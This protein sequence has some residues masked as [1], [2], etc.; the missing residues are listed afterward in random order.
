MGDVAEIA[1]AELHELAAA[2]ASF[3]SNGKPPA[4]E[5]TDMLVLLNFIERREVQKPC[6]NCGTPLLDYSFFRI[7]GAGRYFL[8][9]MTATQQDPS[10]AR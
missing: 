10:N 9:A 2:L 7:T 6:R 1:G 5:A 8:A 3:P 4:S